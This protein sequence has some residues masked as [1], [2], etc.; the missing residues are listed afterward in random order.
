MI[1]EYY[2]VKSWRRRRDVQ[3]ETHGGEMKP[4][5][6]A[7]RLFLTLLLSSCSLP[8][9]RDHDAQVNAALMDVLEQYQYRANLVSKLLAAV[10]GAAN[11]AGPPLA[12]LVAARSQLAVVPAT[13]GELDNPVAFERFEVGQRQ[14]EDALSGLLISI[15]DDRRLA[16][17]PTI[18]RLRA[19]FANA[20]SR[21]A[22]E[23][24]QYDQAAKQYNAAL[25][26]FPDNFAARVFG[27][28]KRSTFD[29]SAL[30]LPRHPP[31]VDFGS[32]R[33]SLRV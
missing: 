4:T 7:F 9:A 29:G 15:D 10:H 21:I 5:A 11:L 13:P 25:D 19:Q 23:R 32:L 27:Y 14:L 26:R 22:T 12:A 28:Q 31:R 16:A 2:F 1:K 6:I 24:D 3:A 8:V 30:A 33:G 20:E 18:C 17:D